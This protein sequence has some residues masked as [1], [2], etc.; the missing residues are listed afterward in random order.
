MTQPKLGLFHQSTTNAPAFDEYVKD[1]HSTVELIK[2]NIKRAQENQ[3]KYADAKRKKHKLSVGDRVFVSADQIKPTSGVTKLNPLAHGPFRI[4][5]KI[6]DVSYKLELPS[7]WKINNSFHIKH[8]KL[9]NDNDDEGI[10][11]LNLG[12]NL[13]MLKVQLKIM[14]THSTISN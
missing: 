6:N 7:H 10:N 8:L 13:T 11:P 12:P 5:K 14:S 2:K 4:V 9:A 1:I 3:K